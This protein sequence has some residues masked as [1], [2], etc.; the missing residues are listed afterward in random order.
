MRRRFHLL[1]LVLVV[2]PILALARWGGEAKSPWSPAEDGVQARLVTRRSVWRAGK[3]LDVFVRYRSVDGRAH[4]VPLVAHGTISHL[5]EGVVVA[6]VTRDFELLGVAR[7][8]TPEA[9]TQGLLLTLPAGSVTSGLHEISGTLGP[10]AL[11][12]LQVRVI[13]PRR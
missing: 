13:E 6:D 3:P 4:D 8:V 2:L 1:L 11:L 7:T 9:R 12:P 10:H 5:R